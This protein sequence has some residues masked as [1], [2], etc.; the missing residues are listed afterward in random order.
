M[1][2]IADSGSTSTNWRHIDAQG[3]IT[4]ARTKGFNPYYQTSAEL[5]E[6]LQHNLIPQLSGGIHQIFFYGAGCNSPSK[7]QIVSKALLEVFPEVIIE[8]HSDLLAVARALCGHEPGIACI[9]GT[10]SNSCYYDGVVIKEH[11]PP[12]GTWLGDEGSGAVLGRQLVIAFLNQELPTEL[13]TSFNKRYPRIKDE[14]LDE[15]YRKPYPNR[16]LGQFSKFLF[17]HKDHVWVY[18]LIY[19]NF[20][21]FFQRKVLKY[22]QAADSPV[23]FSGSIAFYFNSILRQVAQDME[24]TVKNVLETPIAGL[25]LYHQN[26]AN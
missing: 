6:E 14:V 20:K 12:W 16:Y 1:T 21:L 10:G 13:Y 24:V 26:D 15:V 18:D 4:Q 11:I 22:P 19:E 25:T 2:L 17:H 23:H 9:L 7:N 8:V 3:N 5:V